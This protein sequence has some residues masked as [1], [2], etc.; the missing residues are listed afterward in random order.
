MTDPKIQQQQ[1]RPVEFHPN[2]LPPQEVVSRLLSGWIC[3]PGVTISGGSGIVVPGVAGMPTQQKGDV[4]VRPPQPLVP[5]GEIVMALAKTSEMEKHQDWQTLDTFCQ[6]L[7]GVG[8]TLR[9]ILENVQRAPDAPGDNQQ[10]GDDTPD[11]VGEDGSDSE[12]KVLQFPTED[13]DRS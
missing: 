11:S 10:G 2:G 3:I 8:Y 6:T 9:K 1:V 12:G 5:V 7:F 13:I 4:W